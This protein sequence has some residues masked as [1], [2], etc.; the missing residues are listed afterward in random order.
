MRMLDTQILVHMQAGRR[1]EL[2]SG[3][4]ASVAAKEFLIA[5]GTEPDRERYYTSYALTRGRPNGLLADAKTK[6]RHA[7]MRQK[8]DRLLIDFRHE[9]ATVVEYGNRTFA[10]MINYARADSFGAA[11][12]ALAKEE[13]RPLR[14]RFRF[15]VDRSIKC[16]ALE[17]ESLAI[18]LDILDELL[19]G[20]A[21]KVN[22]L[23]TLRDTMILGV[24]V[25]HGVPLQTEDKLLGKLAASRFGVG[26]HD[27]G[28]DVVVDFGT[29]AATA[30]RPRAENRGYINRGWRI[31]TDA[32][33]GPG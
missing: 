27:E 17:E 4:I 3:A 10:E 22:F 8:A 33:P 1:P 5:Y 32:R 19:D 7:T 30:R 24:A 6:A 20:Y 31:A 26:V 16:F 25:K 11:I 9:Q 2:R 15:L 28:E 12:A 18:G 23:N 13:Q 29:A 21:P 14:Q